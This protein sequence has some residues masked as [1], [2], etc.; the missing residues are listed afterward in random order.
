MNLTL[1]H[2]NYEKKEVGHERRKILNTLDEYCCLSITLRYPNPSKKCKVKEIRKKPQVKDEMF[3]PYYQRNDTTLINFVKFLRRS[4]KDLTVS[5]LF[6]GRSQ[7]ERGGGF[8]IFP[9]QTG[10]QDIEYVWSVST[11]HVK[12]L[13]RVEEGR[14]VFTRPPT[15]L[16]SEHI[17]LPSHLRS[18]GSSKWKRLGTLR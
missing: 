15:P 18:R 1:S 10:I 11:T 7:R 4:W 6:T 5:P 14:D 8:Y 9:R 2:K 16:T 17:F 12:T 13:N 3:H